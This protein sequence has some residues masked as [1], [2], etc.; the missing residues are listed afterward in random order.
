M[1]GLGEIQRLE[2]E[3]MREGEHQ[4]RH[5][6]VGV[7]QRQNNLVVAVTLQCTTGQDRLISQI[8]DNSL[9]QDNLEK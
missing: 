7:N 2:R 9:G 5:P 8:A 4:L 1:K 3:T 6:P